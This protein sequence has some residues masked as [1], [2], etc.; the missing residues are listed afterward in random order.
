MI[1]NLSRVDQYSEY[2]LI[3]FYHLNLPG[4]KEVIIKANL[5]IVKELWNKKSLKFPRYDLIHVYTYKLENSSRTSLSPNGN[6]LN[7]G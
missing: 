1:A 5:S 2:I 4:T 3:F 7:P 6:N